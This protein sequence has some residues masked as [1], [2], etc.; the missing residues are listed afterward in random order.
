MR[1]SSK[2]RQI[3]DGRRGC[4]G[5]VIF[6]ELR[7]YVYKGSQG[8][9]GHFGSQKINDALTIFDKNKQIR[10]GGKVQGRA[11]VNLNSKTLKSTI[12]EVEPKE[13]ISMRTWPDPQKSTKNVKERR[14]RSKDEEKL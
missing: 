10:T 1:E 12:I 2:R 6:L 8:S 14:E 9:A 5:S 11:P 13:Q 7:H 3:F 4:K